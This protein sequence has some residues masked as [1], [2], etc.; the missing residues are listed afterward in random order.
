MNDADTQVDLPDLPRE[1]GESPTSD[2][3][4]SSDEVLETNL[5]QIAEMEKHKWIESEK[6]G[7]DLG[8]EAYFDWIAR[9]ARLWRDSWK[10]RKKGGGSE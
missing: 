2:S 8:Q 3:P 6:A 5:S 4:L 1:G 10:Q 9:Y 7:R